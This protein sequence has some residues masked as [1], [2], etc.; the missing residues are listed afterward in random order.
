MGWD[1]LNS[2]MIEEILLMKFNELHRV[3]RKTRSM[4]SRNILRETVTS[5]YEIQNTDD[6]PFHLGESQTSWI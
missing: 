1:V 2:F 4:E 3:Q 5:L 6:K